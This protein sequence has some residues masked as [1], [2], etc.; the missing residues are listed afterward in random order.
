M[1]DNDFAQLKAF[2]AQFATGGATQ[3]DGSPAPLSPK[4]VAIR[5]ATAAAVAEFLARGTSMGA[6]QVAALAD[7]INRP[8]PADRSLSN[9]ALSNTL[10][11]PEFLTAYGEQ[12]KKTFNNNAMG[13]TLMR[14][15]S[16]EDGEELAQAA[17]T[18]TIQEL[19]SSLAKAN[20]ESKGPLS[21][22]DIQTAFGNNRVDA[23][24]R[25]GE[26]TTPGW[27]A[28]KAS[29]GV[30]GV[31]AGLGVVGLGKK[32][33][34]NKALL[35]ISPAL[36]AVGPMGVDLWNG[37]TVFNSADKRF[38][39]DMQKVNKATEGMV[40]TVARDKLRNAFQQELEPL[41][42]A[43]RQ[44]EI[45]NFDRARTFENTTG[46]AA[47]QNRIFGA[48][49]LYGEKWKNVRDRVAGEIG[50]RATN[51][52]ERVVSDYLT[53]PQAIVA[54]VLAAKKTLA[55]RLPLTRKAIGKGLG[56]A[57][58]IAF[59]G[60]V[61][62]DAAED[63]SRNTVNNPYVARDWERGDYGGAMEHAVGGTI[64]D[65]ASR[66][67][68]RHSD[69]QKDFASG[70]GFSPH[71]LQTVLDIGMGADFVANVGAMGGVAED[72]V[73]AAPQ[74]AA[75]A[76][77]GVL[78]E[79]LVG[80]NAGVKTVA[81]MDKWKKWWD[82]QSRDMWDPKKTKNWGVGRKLVAG[83]SAVTSPLDLINDTVAYHRKNSDLADAKREMSIK[84]QNILRAGAIRPNKPVYRGTL[85]M[86][87]VMDIEPTKLKP[88]TWRMSD[89][90]VQTGSAPVAE[91]AAK[92]VTHAIAA[93]APAA[94][95]VIVPQG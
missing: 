51:N 40:D 56:G 64:S 48:Q 87:A 80:E 75:G 57:H 42:Q 3:L 69:I 78:P 84:R 24:N 83:L 74:L 68:K 20:F 95:P 18:I 50:D 32:F 61:A 25:F 35:R 44:Q 33:L 90:T 17:S 8:D 29:Q 88:L 91:P 52:F 89:D 92:P 19:R 23:S 49:R 26:A 6:E 34:S 4:K 46:S 60:N 36:Y 71:L 37:N 81:A 93:P 12:L 85:N 13:Q 10:S 73:Y 82:R 30:E 15:M 77:A 66:A 31:I 21:Q 45:S 55:R 70:K 47:S 38:N 7:A 28:G 67:T 2:I 59:W 11:N 43:E 94:T 22:E 41:R 79:W 63:I 39:A 27:N 72:T 1:A 53:E 86:H 14:L 9:S 54:H 5:E 16:S 62:L 65:I 58:S 76:V